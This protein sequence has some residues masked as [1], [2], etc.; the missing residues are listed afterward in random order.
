VSLFH[1][2]DLIGAKVRDADGREVGHIYEMVAEERN[3][4]LVIVEFHLGS[5][6]VLERVSTSLRSMFG[7]KQK[8]P[9]RVHWDRLDLS[10]P[11]KPVLLVG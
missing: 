6:A 10:D 1:I 11:A 9:V 3:G 8:E 7:L 4:E 2:E 5:G